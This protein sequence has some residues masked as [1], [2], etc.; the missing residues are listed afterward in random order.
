MNSIYS[1]SYTRQ[2]SNSTSKSKDNDS[3][4]DISSDIELNSIVNDSLTD[5][6][7]VMD[8]ELQCLN[9]F[10]S[11]IE[12][13]NDFENISEY[14]TMKHSIWINTLNNLI[15]LH[16]WQNCSPNTLCLAFEYL[17]F[18]LVYIYVVCI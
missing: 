18:A 8:T 5:Y 12:S 9:H 17:N 3:L 7:S 6:N 16:Y 15:S 1:P 4:T 14:I 13:K 2:N 11:D 10:N